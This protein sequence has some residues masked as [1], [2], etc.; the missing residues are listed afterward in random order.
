MSPLRIVFC[1]TPDFA[2]PSLKALHED[3]AFEVLQ[4][5]TQP[6]RLAG[7]G[8]KLT[9]P[10]VKYLAE[11]LKIP[12]LQPENINTDLKP[13]TYNLIPDFLVVV[14]YGQILSERMLAWPKI[15]PI[16]IHA[17]LL[18]Q[19]R[20]ASPIQQ[21]ILAGDTETG[22]TIQRMV[23]KLDAGP[24]LAQEK[25]AVADRETAVSLEGKLA[26][27]GSKLLV[28]TLHVML[29]R[30]LGVSSRVARAPKGEVS[31]GRLGTGSIE[32]RSTSHLETEQ[33]EAQATYCKKL[34]R[35]MGEVDPE[36]MTAEEIDRRVRA[37]V[38]WPGVR[39]RMRGRRGREEEM[40]LIET[41]LVPHQDALAIPCA[42]NTVLY[43]LRLQPPTKRVMTGAEWGRGYL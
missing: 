7:R 38:P 20:G 23:K 24:I 35:S 19:W 13:K 16:N 33:D 28:S 21:A 40:K 11:K 32:G 9:A 2:C 30:Y 42:K 37:L 22:V 29:S 34:T 14:A 17:S 3:S 26:T 41:S 1:G 27:I 25:V 6:D 10:P 43:V 18:P 31:L 5:I 15:A 12:V 8:K 39:M 4:V 36:S